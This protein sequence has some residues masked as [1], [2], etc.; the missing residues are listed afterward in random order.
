MSLFGS[1]FKSEQTDISQLVVHPTRMQLDALVASVAAIGFVDGEFTETE[2][3][4]LVRQ[5][6]AAGWCAAMSETEA[7]A[8][9]EKGVERGRALAASEDDAAI[10]TELAH[11]SGE[12]G[13]IEMRNAAFAMMFAVAAAEGE[14]QPPELEALELFAEAFGVDGDE[15]MGLVKAQLAV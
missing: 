4:K 7:R 14:V 2:V 15:I 8:M 3:A 12:L 5:L 11:L 13:T 9:L 6:E 1:L 10:Q